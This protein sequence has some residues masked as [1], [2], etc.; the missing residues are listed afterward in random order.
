MLVSQVID[1]DTI[2]GA[3]HTHLLDIHVSLID[4]H[5]RLLDINAP[6]IKG[7]SREE[8]LKAKEFL[9]S[10]ILDEWVVVSCE[11]KDKYGR[12]LATVFH[13]GVNINKLMIERGFAVP[14]GK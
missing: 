11:K 10:L 9:Q 13:N 5:F 2:V 7:E 1:G 6:E 14:Y 8:G 4:I 12:Q 3:L